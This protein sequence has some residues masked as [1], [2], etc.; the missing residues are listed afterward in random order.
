MSEIC[1]LIE[2]PSPLERPWS[3]R[4][5]HAPREDESFVADP[6]LA[7]ATEIAELNRER[8]QMARADIQGR[9]L[10]F[11]RQ[12]ARRE[13]LQ[14]ARRYTAGLLEGAASDSSARWSVEASEPVSPH[15]DPDTTTLYVGGHQPTLFH[16]GV[17]VKNF[18][19]GRLAQNNRAVGLNLVVDTDT[20]SGSSIRVPVWR[21]EAP[22]IV[23]V[24]FDEPRPRQPWEEARILSRSMFASFADRVSASMGN[25]GFSPL[26][27]EFWPTAVR[28]SQQ[29]DSLVDCLTAA[30]N[31]WERRWGCSNLE[32]PVSRLCTL[33]PFLWFAAHILAH[34]P[35]FRDVY[36]EVLHE[37]RDVNRVRSRTHPVPDLREA[38]G[39]IEAPFRVWRAGDEVRRRVFARQEAGTIRLW[40]GDEVFAT[41]P[42][43][44]GKDA[45]CAVKELQKLEARG[46]R[47]RTRALTT[48]MFARLCFADLFVHGIG[49][50]KYDQMT[51]RIVSRF[52]GLAAPEF[53]TLSATVQLP[54]A[55]LPADVQDQRRLKR[56]LRD[57]QYNSDRHLP[58]VL[59]ADQ[60]RL[61]HEKQ[62]LVAEQNAVR[63]PRCQS[64]SASGPCRGTGQGYERFRGLQEINRRLAQSTEAERLRIEDELTRTEQQLAANSILRDRE[65]AFCLYPADKLK[66]FIDHVC[67]STGG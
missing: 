38:D 20:M 7:A 50:A 47:F 65:Y 41:L 44:P 59:T 6:P 1:T 55:A 67:S 13:V 54:A 15:I 11:L 18:V 24:A 62:R 4:H 8:L 2:P 28:L 35:R 53:L 22:G 57:L 29:V 34:L 32:L 45:C 31:A 10:G 60:E 51:D 61:V 56:Q 30:R 40:D 33:E 42:L 46:I 21:R 36:N 52:F 17:W 66:R 39:W 3:N 25:W 64:D 26:F 16:P 12:W 14:A 58:P 5:V 37:Y 63:R 49:G 43:A 9:E 48:T 19:V 23:T 27:R